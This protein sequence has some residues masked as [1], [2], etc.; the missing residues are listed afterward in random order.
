MR[1]PTF[2]AGNQKRKLLCHDLVVVLQSSSAQLL[3]YVLK[4]IRCFQSFGLQLIFYLTGHIVYYVCCVVMG[5]EYQIEQ[6]KLDPSAF[7]SSI[8]RRSTTMALVLI[9]TL[10]QK[11]SRKWI[12]LPNFLSTHRCF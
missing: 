10:D 6:N 3:C 12:Y 1:F 2:F 4:N 7:S 11:F 8:K 5:P 9:C